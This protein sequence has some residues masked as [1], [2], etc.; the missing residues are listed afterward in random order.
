LDF[1]DINPGEA[2]LG[3]SWRQYLSWFGKTEQ[4]VSAEGLPAVREWLRTAERN[5]QELDDDEV[6]MDEPRNDGS[7][8][9]PWRQA[10]RDFSRF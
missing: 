1:L 3:K 2:W 8:I 9:R 10:L 4:E 6:L 5:W 7:W